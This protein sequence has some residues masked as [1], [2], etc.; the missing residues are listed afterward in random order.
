MSYFL[1]HLYLKKKIIGWNKFNFLFTRENKKYCS[2]V[3]ADISCIVFVL[4]WLRKSYR[5]SK[6]CFTSFFD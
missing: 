3:H 4:W 1:K 5:K 2:E 6:C